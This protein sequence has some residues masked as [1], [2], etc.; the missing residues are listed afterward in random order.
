MPDVELT[1]ELSLD[2]DAWRESLREAMAD[3]T[4]F[5]D[6]LSQL[7]VEVTAVLDDQVTPE[8]TRIAEDL[9]SREIPIEVTADDELTP[10]IEAIRD[11]ESQRPL[12]IPVTYEATN[13]PD[14]GAAGAPTAGSSAAGGG[15]GMFRKLFLWRLAAE[16]MVRSAESGADVVGEATTSDPAKAEQY[17]KSGESALRK[18]PWVGSL[19]ADVGEG[20]QRGVSATKNWL[21]GRGFQSD[22]AYGEQMGDQQKGTDKQTRD[23][24]EQV[25]LREENAKQIDKQI[26]SENRA[27]QIAGTQTEYGRELVKI[28][29]ERAELADRIANDPKLHDAHGHLTPQGVALQSATTGAIDAEQKEA[30]RQEKERQ[31]KENNAQLA[32]AARVREQ[33]DETMGRGQDA[34]MRDSGDVEGA[35]HQAK[36]REIDAR[37]QQSQD[38]YNYEMD[39]AKKQMLGYAL[40]AAQTTA[41]SERGEA[42]DDYQRQRVSETAESSARIAMASAA[43]GDWKAREAAREAEDNARIIGEKDNDKRQRMYDEAAA[44]RQERERDHK[45]QMGE[46]KTGTIEESLRAS[47]QDDAANLLGIEARAGEDFKDAGTDKDAQDAVRNR[48]IQQLRGFLRG[49]ARPRIFGSITSYSDALQKSVLDHSGG[50][51]ADANKEL[52]RLQGGGNPFDAEQVNQKWQT[53]A[54]NWQKIADQ[55]QANPVFTLSP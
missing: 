35:A 43:P 45:R 36:L 8:V 41:A 23:M 24:Q 54:D 19:L 31:A 11:E 33:I 30:D 40:Q 51:M 12:V 26:E 5:S 9:S 14:D 10:A 39:P 20:A 52:Q 34:A 6:R 32:D 25:K 7:R 1:S 55:I 47:G 13:S 53:T 46:Y 4:E 44:Q 48:E 28:A 27:A 15:F 21:E 29:Q 37:L 3:A 17:R 49:D 50:A 2:L 18:I 38:A 16:G 22:L 42:N